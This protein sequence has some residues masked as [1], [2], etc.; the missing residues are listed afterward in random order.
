MKGLLDAPSSSE[1][2]V[3]NELPSRDP[4]KGWDCLARAALAAVAASSA[5]LTNRGAE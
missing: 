5:D 1:R 2:L 3:T 4:G